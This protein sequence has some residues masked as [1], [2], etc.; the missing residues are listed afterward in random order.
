[1]HSY[2]LPRGDSTV[3]ESMSRTT[4]RLIRMK[5]YHSILYEV[6]FNSAL[7]DIA[8]CSTGIPQGCVSSPLLFTCYTHDCVSVE[9]NQ[10]IVKSSDDTV[11]LS[12]LTKN[13]NVN[14]HYAAVENLVAWCDAHTLQI[15]IRLWKCCWTLVHWGIMAMRSSR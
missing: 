10:Y 3:S 2:T 15:S 12:L 13:S 9:P 5:W 6:R 14:T 8:V 4:R 7:S 1:M 11:L